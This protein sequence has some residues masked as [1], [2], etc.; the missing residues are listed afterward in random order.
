MKRNLRLLIVVVIIGALF[1]TP[2]A[3]AAT[4]L[5][6][7]SRGSAVS[8]LQ[9]KLNTIGYN[10]GVADGI[11]GNNTKAAVMEFQR[12]AG[13]VVDG[14]VGPATTSALNYAYQRKIKTDG[15]ISYSKT[16]IGVP[17]VWGGTTPSGFDCSGYTKYV[18][19]K[20]GITLPRV[21][22]DQYKQG[23]SIAYNNLRPG[24][25]VFFSLNK[26]GQISHVGIYIGNSQFINATSSKGVVISSFT[27][28]WKNVYV[29]A[30]RVY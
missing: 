20:Y 26:N 17:Y 25:L 5:K 29:G 19:A 27:S 18:F 23:T 24:D 22:S 14:I 15:I 2:T 16:L 7:G 9:T 28:Y 12:N 13:L 6:V 4:L 10:S 21:S 8:S 11:F 1:I 30:K 3:N